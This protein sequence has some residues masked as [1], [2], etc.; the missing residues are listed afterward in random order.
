MALD[1]LLK[2]LAVF[3]Q[4]VKE[5]ATSNAISDAQSQVQALN[6]STQDEMA[7]RNQLSQIGNNL[8]LHLAK[9][10]TPVSQ[11]ESAVGFIKPK[12]FK[13]AEDMYVQGVAT[14]DEKLQNAGQTALTGVN[15]PKV[16]LEKLKIAGDLQGKQITADA[17]MNRMDAKQGKDLDN[18]YIVAGKAINPALGRQGAFG[19][20]AKK[21]Y[22]AQHIL[23]AFDQYGDLD[24]M[25]KPLIQEVVTGAASAFANGAVP[26]EGAIR[27]LLP[28]NIN[29]NEA[30]ISSWLTS[31]PRGANQ[32]Q[33]LTMM[34]DTLERQK[35]VSEAIIKQTQYQLLADHAPKLM[36]DP[37]RYAQ[38]LASKG[39][40]SDEYA[41]FIQNGGKLTATKQASGG[42]SNPLMDQL[43]AA[44]QWLQANPSDPRAAGVS[45][46]AQELRSRLGK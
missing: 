43:N 11:I 3:D 2:S 37:S 26:T 5:Y 28:N 23:N 12:A 25:P 33:F 29:M 17:Y 44:E 45:K 35:G 46:R 41:Q 40:S 30:E 1:D 19:E 10:G 21:A 16:D 14:G 24:K 27:G 31:N 38:W 18:A 20:Q 39:L 13:D 36:K 34:K 7:K 4:G 9:V 42:A 8:A 6:Q 32:K 15:K 22:Q